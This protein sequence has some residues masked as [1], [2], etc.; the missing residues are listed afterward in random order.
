MNSESIYRAE[1]R[2]A[3]NN[4]REIYMPE[5]RRQNLAE[6][7]MGSYCNQEEWVEEFLD[8]KTAFYN[9]SEIDDGNNDDGIIMKI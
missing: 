5:E 7:D 6:T 9:G 4:N 1:K 2:K 3:W 8:N